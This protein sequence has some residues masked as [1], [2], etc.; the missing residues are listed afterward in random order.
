MTLSLLYFTQKNNPEDGIRDQ[1]VAHLMIGCYVL[2][3]IFF[4]IPNSFYFLICSVLLEFCNCINM[5]S[6][7]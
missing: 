4:S 6:K 7:Y 2:T 3:N 5:R 1:W